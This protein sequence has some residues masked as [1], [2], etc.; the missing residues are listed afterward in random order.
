MKS[1]IKSGI[2]LSYINMFINVIISFVC[3]PIMLKLMGQSEYGLYSLVAS[4]IG[5]LSVLDMGFGNAM[6]RFV[7]KTT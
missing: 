2:I 1:Q 6:I 4:F 5:Y 7:S 3:I